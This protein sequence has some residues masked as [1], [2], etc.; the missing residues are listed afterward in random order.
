MAGISHQVDMR[1]AGEVQL[2][3]VGISHQVDMRRAGEVQLYIIHGGNQSPGGH[4]EGWRGTAVH[5]G[6]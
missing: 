3:M 1:R 2:Y 5:G 4:E 6:N